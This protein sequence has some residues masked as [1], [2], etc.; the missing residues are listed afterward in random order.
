MHLIQ[1]SAFKAAVKD[2]L[3]ALTIKAIRGLFDTKPI[4]K[5]F[6]PRREKK[7]N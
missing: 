4:S 5:T 3:S 7:K 1:P 6:S 2:K